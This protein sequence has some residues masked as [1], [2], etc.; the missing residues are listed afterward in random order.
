MDNKLDSEFKFLDY[1]QDNYDFNFVTDKGVFS[2]NKINY[3]SIL[4]VREYLKYNNKKLNVLDIGAGYGFIGVV[5]NKITNSNVTL[6]DVSNRALHLC[7][8]NVLRNKCDNISIV[9]SDAYSNIKDSY[10]VIISNPPVN[11]GKD[12]IKEMLDG[13]N[14][15][16]KDGEIWFVILKNN[17]AESLI[18]YFSS[19]YKLNIVYKKKEIYIIR[20]KEC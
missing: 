8:M 3:L 15:L 20:M 18:N 17:G 4:L 10:D 16:N 12:K 13:I 14:H 2:K 5:I 11:A 1:K 9:N 7:K 19:K 6:S